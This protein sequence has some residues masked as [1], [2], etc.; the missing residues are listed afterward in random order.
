MR[1]TIYKHLRLVT[2]S[3]ALIIFILCATPGQ[4]V[5]SAEWLELISFD[6]FVHAFIYFVM[7]SLLFLMTIRYKKSAAVLVSYCLLSFA[8]G[9]VIEVL[10]AF[11]FSHR[12]ADYLDVIA[13]STGCVISVMCFK[14]IRL[15]FSGTEVI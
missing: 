11:V 13:N 7:T 1:K 14:R 9:I 6:K 15:F 5:P 2:I 12:S 3:W 4:Y 8:Y 10:Q